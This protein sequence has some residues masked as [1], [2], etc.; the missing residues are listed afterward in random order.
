M[1]KIQNIPF[2]TH[3]ETK[4]F[5]YTILKRG[6]YYATFKTHKN[7]E[8]NLTLVVCNVYNYY[9]SFL[10]H[11]NN[12]SNCGFMVHNY[13]HDYEFLINCLTIQVSHASYAL[14]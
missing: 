11:K 2:H 1:D 14:S 3:V 9:M 5:F 8:V 10:F 4:F 13:F 7:V 6:K 12:L